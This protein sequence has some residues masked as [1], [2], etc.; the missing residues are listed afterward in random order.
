MYI[1]TQI[2]Y[3]YVYIHMIV[4]IYIHIYVYTY[5]N[6]ITNSLFNDAMS[7]QISRWMIATIQHMEANTEVHMCIYAYTCRYSYQCI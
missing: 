4:H 1:Y 5:M 3:I 2:W 6:M 7:A